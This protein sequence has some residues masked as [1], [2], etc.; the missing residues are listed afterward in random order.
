MELADYVRIAQQRWRFL[1]AC[2]VIGL[3]V[4][5][6]SAPSGAGAGGQ[7][8]AQHILVRSAG[9]R[10]T[11][12]ARDLSTK[13]LLVTNGEVPKRAARQLGWT[14]S[15]QQLARRVS[16]KADDRAGS[17]VI[18]AR[19]DTPSLA[20]KIAN[21]FAEQLQKYLKDQASATRTKAIKAAQARLDE[22]QDEL[23]TLGPVDT[24]EPGEKAQ[25]DAL[26]RQY[27]AAYQELQNLTAAQESGSGLVTLQAATAS[28]AAAGK[29]GARAPQS[30]PVRSGLGFGLGA[31]LAF[32]AAV[33]YERIQ[34]RLRTKRETERAFG[35]PVVAEI[36]VI[37]TEDRRRH[38]VVV[39]E[40]PT[41]LVTEAFRSLRTALLM[42]PSRVL[43]QY[44]PKLSGGNGEHG[45]GSEPAPPLP[46][47]R[48]VR[49]VLVTSPG[50]AEGK[51][52]IVANLAAALAESGHSV[53]V[54]GCD[55]RRPMVHRYF[56]VAQH[57]GLTDCL[58]GGP[59]AP[60]FDEII[61]ET[62]IPGVRVAP[63]GSRLDNP[64][65]VLAAQRK[66]IRHARHYADIVLVDAAPALP[67]ND[68]TDLIPEVDTVLVVCRSGRTSTDSAL[69]F[70]ERLA[71]INAPVLGVVLVGTH[72]PWAYRTYMRRYY[73]YY[74]EPQ[75][76]LTL[77]ALLHPRRFLAER[78][79]AQGSQ[80]ARSASP[81][82]PVPAHAAAPAEGATGTVIDLTDAP[83]EA[84]HGQ[85]EPH[86]AGMPAGD[87]PS[88]G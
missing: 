88:N 35:L 57:P 28:G 30:R 86:G 87:P 55:L 84:A 45:N 34:P 11:G 70:C 47:A 59:N 33:L 39:A 9:A 69:R 81:S 27:A 15:P 63:S 22:L 53:L 26:V 7:H 5:W 54:M 68:A 65:T 18:T 75:P 12:T 52:V 43:T 74:E 77:D 29:Q 64:A 21:A 6:L 40:Q 56:G 20:A 51:T 60:S 36:P 17:L 24:K 79:A 13:A 78:R 46:T 50:P 80:P 44:A 19:A 67:A 14:G 66:L 61:R 83:E 37:R 73:R 1:V 62:S 8:A 82:E 32:V 3:V 2:G 25:R 49:V 16:V 76:R 31:A 23:D 38:A 10:S 71:R 42:M 41:S 72:G 48:P 85:A 58:A 4:A